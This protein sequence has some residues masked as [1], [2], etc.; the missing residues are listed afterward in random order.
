[1]HRQ[2]LTV[3]IA[4]LPMRGVGILGYQPPRKVGEPAGPAVPARQALRP[5][6]NIT[7]LYS[8]PAVA[9]A[10]VVHL[11]LKGQDTIVSESTILQVSFHS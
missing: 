7:T 4:G 5:F 9:T 3:H 1:M 2:V 6:M 10:S 11:Q 8:G